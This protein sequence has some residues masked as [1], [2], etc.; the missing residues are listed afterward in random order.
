MKKDLAK[1]KEREAL[2]GLKH[3][4]LLLK[5]LEYRTGH[6]SSQ[7]PIF[8]CLC[9]CGTE[10]K[11]SYY[12]LFSR[13]T[14][15]CRRCSNRANAHKRWTGYEDISGNFFG[16]LKRGAVNRK[17]EFSVS[18]EYLWKILI[19]QERKC[20]LSGI[21]LKF[22]FTSNTR[23]GN[24]SVDRIDNNKGYIEGNVRWVDKN[25]NMIRRRLTDNDFIWFCTQVA[26]HNKN[27]LIEPDLTLCKEYNGNVENERCDQL[28]T[29][30][31]EPD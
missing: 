1:R 10:T 15:S 16:A 13:R 8:T 27:I 26:N 11:V 7:I 2:I 14:D 25:I 17:L 19:Q 21:N 22:S 6:N 9:D 3:G 5:S 29:S 18:K 4:N 12:A 23:N 20:A 28:A 24:A 31:S 30:C